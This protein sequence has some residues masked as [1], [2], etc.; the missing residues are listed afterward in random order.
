MGAWSTALYGNDCTED[1]RDI[2]L[3]YLKKQYSNEEAY[4]KT[5][6]EFEEVMG[7]DEEALF[8]YAMAETQWKVGRLMP[9]VKEKALNFIA[10]KGG[11][12]LWEE[13]PNKLAKWENTLQKTKEKIESSMPPEKNFRPP[14]HFVRNPWN[15]GDVYAYQF[16]TEEIVG[17]QGLLGKYILFQKVG[18]V[19]GCENVVY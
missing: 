3:E 2:Y 7:T 12:E 19:E 18:D 13:V 8:W 1:V 17:E 6:E 4:Q 11:S 5:Y 9:E 10:E 16:H 14:A 15:L